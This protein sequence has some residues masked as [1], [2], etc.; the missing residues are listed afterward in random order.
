MVDYSSCFDIHEE[1]FIQPYRGGIQL[2]KPGCETEGVNNRL[3]NLN[4]LPIGVCFTDTDH[5]LIGGN[6]RIAE[7]VNAVS[8][9]DMIGGTPDRYWKKDLCERLLAN[10]K[11]IFE[12]QSMMIVEESGS[13]IDD[14]HVL[15]ALSFKYPW[16]YEDKVIGM[17]NYSIPIDPRSLA[18]F[19]ST[20]TQIMTIGLLGP[21]ADIPSFN[22]HPEVKLTQRENEVLTLLLKGHTAKSI[23]MILTLSHRTVEHHIEK[24]RLK[25]NCASKLELIQ[26][27]S[28]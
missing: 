19:S 20:L 2:V 23:A 13:G 5:H 3:T 25:A 1:L 16:F 28:N 14:S 4:E 26:M 15:Q 11:K 17:F 7:M 21:H 18:T 6:D 24:I 12:T 9:D 8:I 22:L 27:Y 10:E